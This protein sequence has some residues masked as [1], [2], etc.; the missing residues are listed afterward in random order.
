MSEKII[1]LDVD[2][3]VADLLTTW[4]RLYNI[5]YKDNLTTEDILDWDMLPYVKEECGK[6]IYDYIG[7]PSIYDYVRP[8]HGAVNGVYELRA[9]GF[10]VIFVTSTPKGC[11]G[12]KLDWLNYW[13]FGVD[14]DSYYEATDKSLIACD[15]LVDDRPLNVENAFGT[16]IIFDAPHNRNWD[17]DRNYPRV[18]NW[19]NVLTYFSNMGTH[20]ELTQ[21]AGI[22]KE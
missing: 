7:D 3:V 8:I 15:F 9:M 5:D 21:K 19:E 14:K 20:F 22:G 11:E 6:R 10:R 4:L 1:G 18:Y 13:G 12:R 16:G 2:D 17:L